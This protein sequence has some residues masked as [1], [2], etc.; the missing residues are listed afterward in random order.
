MILQRDVLSTYMVMHIHWPK[1]KVIWVHFKLVRGK[2]VPVTYLGIA[3]DRMQ[4]KVMLLHGCSM[5]WDVCR[6]VVVYLYICLCVCEWMLKNGTF[7]KLQYILVIFIVE[8]FNL[9][10]EC[11]GGYIIFTK[12][13]L[14]IYNSYEVLPK[15]L[16]LY[17]GESNILV[18]PK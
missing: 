16:S 6:G 8:W 7:M 2:F 9:W 11:S 15:Y 4:Y 1:H 3:L 13:Q 10:R 5:H 17:F 14:I 12:S 18:L